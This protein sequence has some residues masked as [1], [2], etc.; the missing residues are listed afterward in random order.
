[1]S[2][3]VISVVVPVYKSEKTIVRCVHSILDQTLK[4][5]EII[6]VD[7]G[8]PDNSGKLCDE[9]AEND[10]RIRVIHKKNGGVSDARNEGIKFAQAPFVAFVDAD[11][12]VLPNMYEKMY[13]SAVRNYADIVMCG[14]QCE[15]N[16][17]LTPVKMF[18][19]SQYSGHE[20]IRLELIKL[21]YGKYPPGLYSPW[22]K[23]Y[24]TDFLK[25]NKILFDTHLVRAE[26]AWF[27]F[28]CLKKAEKILFISDPLYIYCQ[29]DSSAMHK[30][31][32]NQ[33]DVWLAN[34]KRLLRENEELK[35]EID[36]FDFY[37]D[38]LYKTSVFFRDMVVAGKKDIVLECMKN[39][40]YCTAVKYTAGL[41]V[42]IRFLHYLAGRKKYKVAIAL[43]SLWGKK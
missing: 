33:F 39:E 12:Y 1:M 40:L 20:Q 17:T 36:N 26:D 21:Y 18:Y 15:R 38:F 22:N 5:I 9:L 27:N 23:L 7:D 14:Y 43:C 42:H 32:E 30:V 19:N 13:E 29:N 35:F 25:Y 6:L 11:D 34:R 10:K 24:R 2:D 8:S 4:E 31:L 28:D 37:M 3:A 41:P 16:G